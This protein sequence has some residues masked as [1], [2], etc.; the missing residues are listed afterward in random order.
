MLIGR[1]SVNGSGFGSGIMPAPSLNGILDWQ[2]GGIISMSPSD[3]ITID[4]LRLLPR[5]AR[6]AFAVRWGRRVQ[7]LVRQF[8][9][10]IDAE[11]LSAFDRALSLAEE[12]C[13]QARA[14]EGLAEAVSA[15][16]ICARAA[17]GMTQARTPGTGPAPVPTRDT[18]RYAVANAA[19]AAARAA[20]A[21]GRGDDHAS[22]EA[23]T[24]ACGFVDYAGRA[25]H[26]G[27]TDVVMRYDFEL[28]RRAAE[29]GKLT[30]SAPVQAG[31]LG[32]E[33]EITTYG[34]H[35]GALLLQ[36]DKYVVIQGGRVAGTWGTYED[37]L[38]AG[39][40][41][42]GLTRFLVKRIEETDRGRF[43]PDEAEATCPT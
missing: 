24:N 20:L 6:V 31:S 21:A 18:V 5:W 12:S 28:L 27:S 13:A 25:A 3:R 38:Q 17:A 23:A 7:P 4:D 22:A 29:Q 26:V 1:R 32:L 9:P 42:F 36:Q 37:A 10:N 41:R 43:F 33:E 2:N 35:L 16:D 30:D 19:A 14:V 11:F 15:A 34:R 40:D 39:Y 8:W